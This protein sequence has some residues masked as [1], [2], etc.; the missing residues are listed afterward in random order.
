MFDTLKCFMN[1]IDYYFILEEKDL[2]LIYYK[3]I[4]HASR[5]KANAEYLI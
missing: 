4:V 3:C 1:N 5:L 2:A